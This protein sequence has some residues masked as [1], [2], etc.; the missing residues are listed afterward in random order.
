VGE[1]AQPGLREVVLVAG[2]AVAA[3]LGAAVLTSVLPEGV[4]RIVFHAP[5]AIVVLVAGTAVVLWRVA[6]RRPPEA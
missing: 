3:V 5:L 4:Q 1:R 2:A 6:T